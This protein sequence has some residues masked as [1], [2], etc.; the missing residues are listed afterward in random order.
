M[1]DAWADGKLTHA[2]I[3]SFKGYPRRLSYGG[4]VVDVKIC[5]GHVQSLCFNL[6]TD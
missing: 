2:L 3:P 1:D 4:K 6:E 5:S